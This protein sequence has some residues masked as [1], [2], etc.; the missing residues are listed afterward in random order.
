VTTRMPNVADLTAAEL[1]SLVRVSRGFV[2]A[3]IPK[4]H[5]ARLV[6]LGLIQAIMGGLMITP[7]GRMVARA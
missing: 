6:E 5:Q 2:C 3:T 4:A 7:M 1:A